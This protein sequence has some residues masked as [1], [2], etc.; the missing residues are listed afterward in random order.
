MS[1]VQLSRVT[2]SFGAINVIPTMDLSCDEGEFVVIVGPSGCGKSTTLRMIA[3]LEEFSSG[4][5]FI[6]G[7]DVTK[8]APKERD[9]AMVLGPGRKGRCRA[10][11]PPQLR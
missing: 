8:A 9:I 5:V 3:G 11:P 7:K 6:A 2:K 1:G 10:L 4:S